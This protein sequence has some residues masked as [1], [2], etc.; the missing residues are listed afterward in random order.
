MEK[1]LTNALG[2]KIDISHLELMEKSLYDTVYTEAGEVIKEFIFF[3]KTF[4]IQKYGF[5]SSNMECPSFLPGENY[6]CVQ[7]IEVI[8]C[9]DLRAFA[10]RASLQFMIGCK[11]FIELP[12]EDF[13]YTNSTRETQLKCP[14]LLSPLQNFS[15]KVK[16]QHAVQFNFDYA[17]RCKLLGDYYRPRA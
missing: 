2:K 6:F 1:P 16:M 13:W 11:V 9:E 15:A 4:D 14:L 8:D 12:L 3:D 17:L 10:K 7:G 5:A